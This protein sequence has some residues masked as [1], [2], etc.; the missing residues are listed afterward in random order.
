MRW[1]NVIY[2]N[3]NHNISVSQKFLPLLFLLIEEVYQMLQINHKNLVVRTKQKVLPN[4]DILG[5]ELKMPHLRLVHTQDC[6]A[7]E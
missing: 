3:N 1:H 2:D 6:L 7:T 4:S 5:K